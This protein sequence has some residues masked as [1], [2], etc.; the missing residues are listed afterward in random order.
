MPGMMT[1]GKVAALTG[2]SADAIR[3]YERLGLFTKPTRT[4]AGY[5]VYPP[6]IVKRLNLVRNAQRFGFSLRE[7]AGFLRVR[8]TG[9]APCRTVRA[10][11]EQLLEAIDRQIADLGARREEMRKTLRGWD[12]RFEEMPAGTPR[13][14]LENL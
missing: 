6:E 7:I 10:A 3:Y 11:A 14:L 8:D 13:R 2:V 1:I 5:R 12:R 9:G 4:R